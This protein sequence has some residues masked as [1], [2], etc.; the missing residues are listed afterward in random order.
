M[1]SASSI[2]YINLVCGKCV[3]SPKFSGGNTVLANETLSKPKLE[4]MNKLNS[5]EYFK[6]KD[7]LNLSD[8][9][10]IKRQNKIM[11]ASVTDEMIKN[12]DNYKLSADKRIFYVNDKGESVK[13]ELDSKIQ[14]EKDKLYPYSSFIT[15]VKSESD[16]KNI[17]KLFIANSIIGE[18]SRLN[19]TVYIDKTSFHDKNGHIDIKTNKNTAVVANRDMKVLNVLKDT[20][21]TKG[22]YIVTWETDRKS[23]V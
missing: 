15:N 22:Y 14:P 11:I 4:V 13:L 2:N 23:V 6:R 3:I 18:N 12:I 8:E 7:E 10:F 17:K 16:I 5:N 1:S 19:A 20:T 21:N 9:E